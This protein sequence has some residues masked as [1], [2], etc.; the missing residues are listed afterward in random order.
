MSLRGPSLVRS[1]FMC[2]TGDLTDSL[3]HSKF[4]MFADDVQIFAHCPLADLPRTVAGLNDDAQSIV[5]WANKN[6]MYLNPSKTQSMIL[7]SPKSVKSLDLSSVPKICVQNKEIDYSLVLKNLGVWLS[8]D[9]SWSRHIVHIR[10]RVFC[11]LHQL[12][13]ARRCLTL[14]MRKSLTKALISPHLDYCSLLLTGSPDGIDSHLKKLMNCAIRFIFDIRGVASIS[15]YY[16]ELDWLTPFYQRQ[17]FLGKLIYY[18]L[19]HHP[20]HYLAGR[21]RFISESFERPRRGSALDLF[22][23]FAKTNLGA[24][25]FAVSGAKMWNSIPDEI[26]RSSSIRLFEARLKTFLLQKQREIIQTSYR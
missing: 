1:F 15:L 5:D 14:E 6:Y 25:T 4:A 12:R 9:L 19:N 2:F 16:I 10:E 11:S 24:C 18:L 20:S 7:G 23:N 13:S 22:V 26:R 3:K 17:F 21:F 8:H